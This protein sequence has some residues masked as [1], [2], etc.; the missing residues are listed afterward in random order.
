[1]TGDP[2]ADLHGSD[3]SAG[4]NLG[5]LYQ[6]TPALRF[7]IDYRSRLQN[8]ISGMQTVSVPSAISMLA[9]VTAAQLRF[10]NTPVTTKMT[11]PDSVTIGGYWQATPQLALLSDVSWTDWSLLK[12]LTV[13]PSTPGVPGSTTV[14]NWR[15][16]IA[17]SVGAN[18]RLTADWLLQG[19]VGF[20][21][22]PVPQDTRNTRIP[23]S[24]RY[25]IGLGAQYDI[26]PNLTLQVAYAHVFFTG[27]ELTSSSTTSAGVLVGK[28]SSSADTASVGVKWRF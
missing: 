4:F 2:V 16:T 21:Q 10:L 24:N 3:V 8:D 7:G 26:L 25:L 18:Y 6:L 11:L 28:Y 12:A 5:L 17:L 22:T 23:D 27:A 19:G 9:P 20:D 14:E 13:T 15:N 1:L